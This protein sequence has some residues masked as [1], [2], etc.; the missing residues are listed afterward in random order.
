LSSI[1]PTGSHVFG[2]R[3]ILQAKAVNL[4]LLSFVKTGIFL[5]NRKK[6]YQHFKISPVPGT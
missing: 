5:T 1:T 4:A 6:N 3:I 2:F